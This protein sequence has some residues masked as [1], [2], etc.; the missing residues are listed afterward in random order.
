MLEITDLFLKQQ[1][2]QFEHCV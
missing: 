1:L 2:K